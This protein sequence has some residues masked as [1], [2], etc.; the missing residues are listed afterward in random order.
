MT[1]PYRYR[2]PRRRMLLRDVALDAVLDEY[3]AR[4][5][6]HLLGCDDDLDPFR[7]EVLAQRVLAAATE[8]IERLRAALAAGDADHVAALLPK[9]RDGVTVS[10]GL[11]RNDSVPLGPSGD[12]VTAL[13]DA[14][15][16][17]D[18]LLDECDIVA[19][20]GGGTA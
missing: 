5:L 2:D 15:D 12:A 4:D 7:L 1:V 20:L 6:D 16:A 13:L 17:L 11:L 18:A 3:G 14:I 19:L 9:T 8:R 10:S